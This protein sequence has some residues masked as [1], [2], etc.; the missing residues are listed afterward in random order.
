M[1]ET[2][3]GTNRLKGQLPEGTAVAHK[4]GTSGREDNIMAAFNDIGIVTLPNGKHYAIAVFITNSK[5]NDEI[6]A[7]IIAEISKSVWEYFSN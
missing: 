7:A 2:T 1:V 3:T 5:E 6:N 4:T